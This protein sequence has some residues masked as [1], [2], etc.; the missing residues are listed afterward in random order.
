[1]R[2]AHFG[3]WWC[4]SKD[5]PL[6]PTSADIGAQKASFSVKDAFWMQSAGLAIATRKRSGEVEKKGGKEAGISGKCPICAKPDLLNF[7]PTAKRK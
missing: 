5:R 4:N 3:A 6:S 2:K 7:D 1:V